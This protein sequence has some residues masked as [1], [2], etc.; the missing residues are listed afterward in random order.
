M[1]IFY[2]TLHSA[3]CWWEK[4]RE[5]SDFPMQP[6]HVYILY[7]SMLSSNISPL[8]KTWK[9]WSYFCCRQGISIDTIISKEP[10]SIFFSSFTSANAFYSWR[11]YQLIQVL[12]HLKRTQLHHYWHWLFK[13]Y[14]F[15]FR[16]VLDRQ[17][18]CSTKSSHTPLSLWFLLLLMSY[19]SMAH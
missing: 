9:P 17:Q 11:C 6:F 1:S 4:R 13:K 7:V 10:V 18:N 14:T 2:Y 12:L 19:I 8:F 5:W 16:R 15:Y 3:V